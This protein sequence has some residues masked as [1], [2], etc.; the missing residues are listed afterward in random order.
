MKSEK[1]LTVDSLQ[2]TVRK[3]FSALIIIL[4]VAIVGIGAVAAFGVLNVGDIK[5]STP[6]QINQTVDDQQVRDLQIL[7]SSDKVSDIEKDLND[8]KLNEIDQELPQIENDAST[9]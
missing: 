4:I 2:L 5:K 3:G 7:G 6:T 1:Q 9:L 8:T